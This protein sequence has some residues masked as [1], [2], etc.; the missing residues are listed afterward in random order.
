MVVNYR[1]GALFG[2][3][4]LGILAV[5][6]AQDAAERKRHESALAAL[7]SQVSQLSQDLA[8]EEAAR[9][10]QSAAAELG[11]RHV[12][13]APSATVH[14]AA[15]APKADVPRPQPS[16]GAKVESKEE[17]MQKLAATRSQFEANFARDTP[18]SSWTTNDARKATEKVMSDLPTGSTLQSFECRSSLCRIETTH[19][20]LAAERRFVTTAFINPGS[21]L[22]NAGGFSAPSSDQP[23]PDGR[24]DTVTYISREGQSLPTAMR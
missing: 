13:S 2:L 17:S 24:V 15:A 14:P 12:S 18:D 11:R 9:S 19:E 22:W 3:P 8:D 1:S 6:Y 4:I 16:A 21:Q 10:V 5:F 7:R 20:S 23:S